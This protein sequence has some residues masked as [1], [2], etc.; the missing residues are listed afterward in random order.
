VI[1]RHRWLDVVLC[2]A[3]VGFLA[4][5]FVVFVVSWP[6][7]GGP[8]DQQAVVVGA[9]SVVVLGSIIVGAVA[10]PIERA[11]DVGPG[12]TIGLVNRPG[13][14]LLGLSV[15][16][17]SAFLFWLASRHP[18]DEAALAAAL[19]AAAAFGGYWAAARRAL[20]AA[21]SLAMSQRER[22]RLV[23]QVESV[24]KLGERLATSTFTGNT[25]E[26]VKVLAIN[27]MRVRLGRV[28]VNQLRTY[29]RR[30][31]SRGAT[32]EGLMFYEA[33]IDAFVDLLR[34][35][36]GATGGFNG[37]PSD[38]VESASGFVQSCRLHGDDFVAVKVVEQLARLASLDSTHPDVAEVRLHARGHIRAILER[39][40]NEDDSRVPATAAD[41]LGRLLPTFIE[42]QAID[43]AWMT[44]DQVH[45]LILKAQAGGKSH[46]AQPA[47]SG[48]VRSMG[49]AM[50]RLDSHRRRYFLDHWKDY[51]TQLAQLKLLPDMSFVRAQDQLI[52]GLSTGGGVQ[53]QIVLQEASAASS[54][55]L[56][57]A[58]DAICAWMEEVL[59]DFA[60]ADQRAARHPVSDGLDLL[61]SCGLL[62]VHYRASLERQGVVQCSHQLLSAATGWTTRSEPTTAARL[63]FAEEGVG[64]H[65]WSVLLVAAYLT[66]DP[67]DAVTVATALR[68]LFDPTEPTRP[69][70]LAVFAGLHLFTGTPADEVRELVESVQSRNRSS[71]FSIDRGVPLCARPLVHH[72][73]D[74]DAV[75]EWAVHRFPDL[76]PAGPTPIM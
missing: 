43:E 34:R 57:D 39:A 41:L 52:P 44:A 54:P 75:D 30:L 48:F 63:L 14:W 66:D 64:E 17:A 15:A 18:D 73:A 12:L 50:T 46:I 7:H 59:P 26:N 31:F 35:T 11:A 62:V 19:L 13:L 27:D 40:W 24:V 60:K 25:P 29:A 38:V 72:P 49:T 68:E 47:M 6:W 28:P 58:T 22:T 23:R 65:T 56:L 5:S 4:A 9:A 33:T 76:R 61:L 69:D 51:A 70:G 55:G 2:L 32:D 1:A 42:M 74:V 67:T 3:P 36:S 53:L 16:P 37:L 8:T 10:L 20:A 45:K 21:D 71:R